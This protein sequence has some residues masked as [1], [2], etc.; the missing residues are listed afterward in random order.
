MLNKKFWFTIVWLTTA[1]TLYAMGHRV[2]KN[3]DD[4][5]FDAKAEGTKATTHAKEMVQEQKAEERPTVPGEVE[6]DTAK[7]FND[8]FFKDSELQKDITPEEK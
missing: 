1:G 2:E 5:E 7:G 8:P 6:K 4:S 3:S